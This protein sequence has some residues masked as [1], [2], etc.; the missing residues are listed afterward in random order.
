MTRAWLLA[1]I[2]TFSLGAASAQAE[3]S[4]KARTLLT[5]ARADFEAQPRRIEE[6]EKKLRAT[7]EEA[8]DFTE[9]RTLLAV[10]LIEGSKDDE[11]EV[12]LE[13]VL[14]KAPDH[15]EALFHLARLKYYRD[16]KEFDKALELFQK[17]TELDPRNPA[18]HYYIGEIHWTQYKDDKAEQAY[19]KAI[20]VDPGFAKPYY[21]LAFLY[22]KQKKYADSEKYA[23]KAIEAHGNDYRALNLLGL[24]RYENYKDDE[25]EALYRKAL[26]HNP[27]FG[28]AYYN[29]G[30]LTY[31]QQKYKAARDHFDKAIQYFDPKHQAQNIEKTRRYLEKVD[32]LL[33]GATKDETPPQP[34]TPGKKRGT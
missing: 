12:V 34:P 8:P 18:A 16:K 26:E 19:L 9:A 25:A 6:A 15:V 3:P 10:V 23:N 21:T 2:L 27:S 24:I 33:K 5:A 28:F 14:S 4:L 11:A 13:E 31:S 1:L 29:L 32:Q 22:Y 17:V 7:L 20:Q 30:M